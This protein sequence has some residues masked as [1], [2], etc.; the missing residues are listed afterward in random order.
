MPNSLWQLQIYI[1]RLYFCNGNRILFYYEDNL[2]KIKHNLSFSHNF[3]L[4][5]TFV[6]LYIIM[7]YRIKSYRKIVIKQYRK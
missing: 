2:N 1:M 4:Q 6:P 3:N 7:E 5:P